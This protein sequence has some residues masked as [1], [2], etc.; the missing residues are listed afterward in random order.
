MVIEFKNALGI[1]FLMFFAPEGLFCHKRKL[2]CCN[3]SF[4]NG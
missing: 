1:R 3:I 2:V 4:K